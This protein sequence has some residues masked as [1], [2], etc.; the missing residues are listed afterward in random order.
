MSAPDP[1]ELLRSLIRFDTVNPPG[2]ERAA[3]EHLAGVL[4]AAGFACELLG[5]TPERPN[6]LARLAGE[7]PG[8]V[9]CL[10][11]HVDTVLANPGE[12]TH[13][14]WSG[15][16]DG[17]FVWGRGALDMKG[18]TAAEVAAACALA[19]A[20]WRPPRGT[21][22][23]VVV[24]DEETGGGEGAVWL[25]QTHPE[26]VRCDYLVNEGG[27]GIL[28]YG[29]RRLCCLG[30]GEKGIFRFVLATGGV[31][32]HASMPRVGENA[33]VKLA[34][35]LARLGE[36]QPSYALTEHPRAF[37][38]AVGAL[39]DGD[40][41]A[42]VERIRATDPRL[43]PILEPM[44]GV[45]LAPTRAFGSDKINVIPS[46]ARLAVD[47]RV[48]P[49]LG[50][51]EALAAI[52]EVLGRD[53]YGLEWTEQVPGNGSSFESPLARFI[54]GWIGEHDPDATVVP[55]IL[56]GF[57][58]SCTFRAAFPDCAAYGFMPHRHT[59]RFDTD[60]LIHGADERIDV[61]DLAYA[62]EFFGD[63]VRGMLA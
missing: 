29:G 41:A 28:D 32:A 21:L 19:A 42:A 57:T 12:W 35:L 15:D 50:E 60:H 45:S 36:R 1:V 22:L 62:T 38:E 20:G 18:Q 27:G 46:R 2:N 54:R 17:G 52:E 48:P 3:Q 8:P 61:R 5:R 26:K 59:T 58:D 49:G 14:P 53:G 37:L 55:V 47:C 13:D 11:S 40:V 10:L 44:L 30:C 24:A 51:A 39:D 4:G 34:P 25:T 23:V 43:V 16:L 9:L 7:R 31:A 56:P 33:L 63:L 6:L